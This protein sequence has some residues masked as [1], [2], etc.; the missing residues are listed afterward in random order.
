MPISNAPFPTAVDL[1][2]LLGSPNIP[3][4][5]FSGSLKIKPLSLQET[6]KYNAIKTQIENSTDDLYT[7]TRSLGDAKLAYSK[8]VNSLP[9]GDPQITS[10]KQAV[11]D[12]QAKVTSLDT[13]IAT[14]RQEQATLATA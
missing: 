14:L 4:P 3:L 2:A 11:D 5:N 8:A 13:K 6:E 12:A 9:Q 1:S 7:A 10:L